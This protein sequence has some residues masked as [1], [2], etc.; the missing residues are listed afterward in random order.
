MST[1]TIEALENDLLLMLNP[2][3]ASKDTACVQQEQAS[4][5][6]SF[7]ADIL[8]AYPDTHI[9]QSVWHDYLDVTRRPAFLGGLPSTEARMQWADLMFRIVEFSQYSLRDMFEQRVREHPQHAL[10]KE[11][12]KPHAKWTYQQVFEY[13][14]KIAAVFYSA[15]EQPRGPYLPPSD[16]S[17]AIPWILEFCDTRHSR[18]DGVTREIVG[19]SSRRDRTAGINARSRLSS[20]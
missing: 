3:R 13:M 8:N 19:I 6:L 20:R 12:D 7:V 4:A 11:A 2:F 16:F 18:G 15:A 9:N 1:P 14:K 10:F 5:L 17:T